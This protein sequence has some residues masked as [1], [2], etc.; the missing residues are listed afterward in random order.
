[1]VRGDAES[2]IRPGQFGIGVLLVGEHIYHP[3]SGKLTLK[4]FDLGGVSGSFELNAELST[5][6]RSQIK[7]R[8]SFEIPCGDV[9]Q[10]KCRR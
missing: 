3:T 4:H 6:R 1:L 10:S 7:V 9:A 8:G 5:E 2:E